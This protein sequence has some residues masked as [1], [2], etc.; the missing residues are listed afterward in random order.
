MMPSLGS[1]SRPADVPHLR[2]AGSS[3]QLRVT[4]GAGFGSPSPVI[5]FP[6]FAADCADSVADGVRRESVRLYAVS[7]RTAQAN[8]EESIRDLGMTVSSSVF[9]QC[10][11][12]GGFTVDAGLVPFRIQ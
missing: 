5:G 9:D 7:R 4:F 2:P 1:M 11:C 3:P 10:S 6:A 12:T 8:V